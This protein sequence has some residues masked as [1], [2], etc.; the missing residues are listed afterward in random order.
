MSKNPMISLAF[1]RAYTPRKR[2]TQPE[3]KRK[4]PAEK[5]S[6]FVVLHGL[7]ESIQ[8]RLR[9]RIHLIKEGDKN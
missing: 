8:F 4:T 1:A 9:N 6:P 2:K 7:K 5:K 3:R